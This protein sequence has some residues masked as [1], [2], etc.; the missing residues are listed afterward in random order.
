LIPRHTV[1]EAIDLITKEVKIMTR[2]IGM[3]LLGIWLIAT[4][5]LQVIS[6][7]IPGIGIIMAI[8]AMVAGLF[9]LI[10]K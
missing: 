1:S 6:V 2:R 10:G 8:L 4:G 5:L 3:I 7:A 9:I